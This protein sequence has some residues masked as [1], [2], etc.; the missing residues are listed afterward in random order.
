M[1]FALNF[2]A[3]IILTVC[4]FILAGCSTCKCKSID[5][6]GKIRDASNPA[7]VA[8]EQPLAPATQP[9]LAPSTTNSSVS[10]AQSPS[11][12]TKE[13]QTEIQT[14]SPAVSPTSE[15]P[16][17]GTVKVYKY[18]NSRQCGQGKAVSLEEMAK[19]FKNIKIISQEK[20]NDG[21]MR[22]QMCGAPT[23]V[24]NVYEIDQKDAKRAAKIGFR[25]WKYSQQ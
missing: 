18:D 7:P 11:T 2:V 25:E 14:V 16:A 20:K 17:A 6:K 5:D 10:L 19:E 8:P 9:N 21:M 13:T 12:P 1:K 15:T 24:A 23:G 22:I 4:V 3:K